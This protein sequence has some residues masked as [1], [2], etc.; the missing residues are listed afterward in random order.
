MKLKKFPITSIIAVYFDNRGLLEKFPNSIDLL[1]FLVGEEEN[2]G[3]ETV[4]QVG[5]EAYDR[6]FLIGKE[7]LSKMYPWLATDAK[8][9]KF[10]KMLLLDHDDIT[11][12]EWQVKLKMHLA[13]HINYAKGDNLEVIL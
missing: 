4:G 3:W 7:V 1:A 2:E 10:G 9:Q 5:Q 13:G 8:I 6:A 11:T 12:L